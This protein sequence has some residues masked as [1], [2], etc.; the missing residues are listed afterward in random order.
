MDFQALTGHAN[1]QGYCRR[2]VRKRLLGGPRRAAI[3]E[4]F[5][6]AGELLTERAEQPPPRFAQEGGLQKL[7]QLALP[8]GG[9]SAGG[10]RPHGHP[11]GQSAMSVDQ[12]VAREPV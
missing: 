3:P 2:Q 5:Q 8:G 11:V 6:V 4:A 7:V 1:P 9:Q 12:P 10:P